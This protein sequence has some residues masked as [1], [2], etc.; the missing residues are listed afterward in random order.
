MFSPV[1]QPPEPA[2]AFI[3]Q[4]AMHK[5]HVTSLMANIN[6]ERNVSQNRRRALYMGSFG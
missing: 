4:R 2:H 6:A 1:A 5:K 3:M